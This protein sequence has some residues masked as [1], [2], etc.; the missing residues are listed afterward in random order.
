MRSSAQIYIYID[1][2]K[3][4]EGLNKSFNLI[5][6]IKSFLFKMGSNS[7]FQLIM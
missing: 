6:L 5:L 7:M 3:A 2:E 4:L 1:M